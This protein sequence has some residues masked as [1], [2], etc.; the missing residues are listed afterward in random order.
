MVIKKQ[1]LKGPNNN[2]YIYI[3]GGNETQ[4]LF[5]KIMWFWIDARDNNGK[6][7]KR[8][9]HERKCKNQDEA[10]NAFP[11]RNFEVKGSILEY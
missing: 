3:L 8:N 2:I 6:I 9:M 10:A 11:W 1:Q 7:E 5:M 4:K